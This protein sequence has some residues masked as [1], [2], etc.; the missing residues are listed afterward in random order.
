MPN[1]KFKELNAIRDKIKSAQSIRTSKFKI[2]NLV[3]TQ[4]LDKIAL[5]SL[6]YVRTDLFT[7]ELDPCKAN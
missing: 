7:S 6:L 3:L 2:K 5:V 4:T 1:P